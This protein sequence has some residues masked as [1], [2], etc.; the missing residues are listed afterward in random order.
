MRNPLWRFMCF[1]VVL[2]AITTAGSAAAGSSNLCFTENQG[3]WDERVKFRAEAGGAVMWFTS[4]GICY[5]FIRKIEKETPNESDRFDLQHERFNH[6]ADSCEQIVVKAAFENA[7]PNL[8]V[9]GENIMEY[10]CNYFIGNDP[11]NWH[12]D[13][14]NYTGIIMKDVYPGID[15]RYF[16]N[17]DG[18]LM[19]EF[20]ANSK[21]DLSQ[22]QMSYEGAAET[23]ID[24][25]GRLIVQTDWGNIFEGLSPFSNG[26]NLISP[27][28][29][30]NEDASYAPADQPRAGNV[31]LVYSTYLGGNWLDF[32]TGIV[33]DDSQNAYVV[34]RSESTDFPTLNPYQAYNNATDVVISRIS[35]NGS[36][37]IYSTYLGGSDVD[38]AEDIAIDSNDCVYVAGD[39]YSTDF[40]LQ[41]PYQGAKNSGSDAFVFKLSAS[42]NSLVYSTYLGDLSN[43]YAYDIEVDGHGRAYVTGTTYS[44]S[45]PTFNSYQA[46]QA[47]PDAFVTK[48][49]DAGNSL[50][51]ST[52]LGGSSV[53]H[54][55]AIA[56]DTQGN[57]Y[58]AGYT[59]STDFP[60]LN[61]Y[62]DS[63]AGGY[64]I[65][66]TKIA[67]TGSSLIYSTYLGGGDDDYGYDV[68]IDDYGCAY[69]TGNTYSS[70][71]PAVNPYMTFQDYCD[72]FVTKLSSSGNSLV[73]ST[74]LGGE[75]FETGYCI[76][77]D[78]SRCAYVSGDTYSSD[79]PILNAFQ[80]TNHGFNTDVFLTKLSY[81]G[82]TLVFSTFLGGDQEESCMDIAVD[83]LGYAYLTGQTSSTD[84]P[85]MNPYQ[86]NQDTTDI[87]I[88]KI[89]ALEEPQVYS[90]YPNQNAVNVSPNTEISA[91]FTVPMDSSSFDMVNHGVSVF[92]S[93][94]GVH[95]GYF[96]YHDPTLTATFIP[97]EPFVPGEIVTVCVKDG[98][99]SAEGINLPFDYAWQFFVGARGG[100]GILVVDTSQIR[101]I[102]SSNF[103]VA[104]Y[105]NDGYFDV[106]IADS[107]S[108]SILVA[109]NSSGIMG[110]F[111]PY[112]GVF[113]PSSVAPI[114]VDTSGGPDIFTVSMVADAMGIFHNDGSGGFPI[115]NQFP[116]PMGGIYIAYYPVFYAAYKILGVAENDSN[117]IG[118]YT[119]DF[120]SMGFDTLETF[121]VGNIP[122][123]LE[124]ADFDNDG[125]LDIAVANQSSESVTILWGDDYG[126]R[127]DYDL[128]GRPLDMTFGDYNQD[129]FNDI[130]TVHYDGYG[131][132]ILM[133]NGDRT[134]DTTT[135]DISWAFPRSICTADFDND[136]FLDLAVGYQDSGY[137]SLYEN[138]GNG[139]FSTPIHHRLECATTIL[140]PFDF[141]N[142]GSVD[143]AAGGTDYHY[144]GKG[145]A[146]LSN[147]LQDSDSDSIPDNIDNCPFVANFDQA[148]SDYDGIGDACDGD[149]PTYFVDSI[150]SADLYYIQTADLDRDNY[151]DLVYS[152]SV[153]TGLFI[154][155][156]NPGDTLEAPIILLDISEAAIAID[157]I[158]ADTLLDIAAIDATDI[159][160][161]INNGSRSF[162][163][164]V[165]PLSKQ[166]DRQEI[167]SIV[168][169]YFNDD[170]YVDLVYAPDKIRF[171]NGDGTFSSEGTICCDFVSAQVCDF[172]NDGKDDLLTND[173]DRVEI[174]LQT[175]PGIF[176]SAHTIYHAS[177]TFEIPPVSA[178]ADLNADCYCDFAFTVPYF[179]GVMDPYTDIYIAHTDGYG[180]VQDMPGMTTS[181]HIFEMIA[182][183][184]NRDNILDLVAAN[185]TT[186]QLEIYYGTEYGDYTS[187]Q[188]VP[189]GESTGS[190]LT[191][192]LA[193]L[194]INRDGNYD[195]VAGGPDGE[196][197]AVAIDEQAGSTESLDEMVV[198]GYDYID[199]AVVNPDQFVISE[200]TQTVAGSDFWRSDVDQNGYLDEQTYDYNLQYGD[201][202]IILTPDPDAP[203][204]ALFDVGVK[205]NGT[206]NAIIFDGYNTAD[207]VISG[208]DGGCPEDAVKFYYTVEPAPSIQPGNG[209]KAPSSPIFDWSGLIGKVFPEGSYHFQ[210]DRYYDFR[211][212]IF[213]TAGLVDP[214]YHAP[215]SL[216]A[217]SVFYWRF[218]SYS[219]GG[220][221]EFSHTFAVYILG[222]KCGDSNADTKVNV[223]D[224]V[225]IINYVFVGGPAPDP[226]NSA[227]V[228][229]DG[230]V[231]VSDAVYIINFVFIGGHKPCDVDGDLIPD[232]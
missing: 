179:D 26:A 60:T 138:P 92:G 73:Y 93:I 154:A 207:L 128:G 108:D 129:G 3:Q 201:Y 190:D 134:F 59:N 199:I 132:S 122:T 72:V 165:I 142:D 99:T 90:V 30:A 156:G 110:A 161:L 152:G 66:I 210:L 192:V 70:D 121:E 34:G 13:V 102:S 20:V 120:A 144:G 175:S 82:N 225:Y 86:T 180:G 48:F 67:S 98:A 2:L 85:T 174:L 173:I 203:P 214:Q 176:S 21:A 12:T 219:G 139:N 131:L 215:S 65:F 50:I 57:A 15:I 115:V 204:D 63:F 64:D 223:S 198:T 77:L 227:E 111:T 218:R 221:T 75:F 28:S 187:P 166:S 118:L 151:M 208:K 186:K 213:D 8:S 109:L 164:S 78:A 163:E 18:N 56:I 96:S 135:V 177:I 104:D 4:D 36:S 107:I 84:F 205:V 62:Q 61:P 117:Q 9:I 195:F 119:F 81:S 27:G 101:S 69:V 52:Y 38:V 44:D 89:A 42:G 25:D 212:P 97:V 51:Y 22:V 39:T 103:A 216:G 197:L 14:P 123:R 127:T 46:N 55:Y 181:G 140:K 189:V 184:V 7:N 100:S 116:T 229:C 58:V 19:C 145:F 167:N 194:D 33:I 150:L 141:N 209:M 43:D 17:N 153:D 232:C 200:Q 1:A 157:Y 49:S 76:A 143:L 228:N 68:A 193:T 185:G 5:Q 71:F 183:D 137:V 158:N 231:N 182:A 105:N 226:M 79:F 23:Y 113:M 217:D 91:T 35:S 88:A 172:N 220:W 146:M 74:F 11:N 130:A 32:G 170:E 133:N 114:P 80:E 45:F 136:G 191:Y 112:T 95:S 149:T 222:Y 83:N 54:S 171:G 169:G 94:S 24:V 162:T 41:N 196:N 47:G 126:V 87:F 53:E 206:V 148:D 224:A 6:E 168:S 37:L 124:F 155:Y 106:A 211:D 29:F 16:A 31:T 40:P 147:R 125:M 230:S 10:K 159:H 178:I 160:I 202:E 188:Y